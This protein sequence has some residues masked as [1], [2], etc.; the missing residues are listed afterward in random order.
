MDGDSGGLLPLIMG[1][2]GDGGQLR[3]SVRPANEKLENVEIGQWWHLVRRGL[4]QEEGWKRMMGRQV[5]SFIN[6][7]APVLPV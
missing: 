1:G 6:S 7:S 2:E 3:D 5:A 4:R